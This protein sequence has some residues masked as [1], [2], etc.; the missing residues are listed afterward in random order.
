MQAFLYSSADEKTVNEILRALTLK[1][2]DARLKSVEIIE[3][4]E[5]LPQTERQKDEN[6]ELSRKHSA[7]WF[8]KSDQIKLIKTL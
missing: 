5:E 2:E 1:S 6:R 4:N 3:R 7:E 8:S